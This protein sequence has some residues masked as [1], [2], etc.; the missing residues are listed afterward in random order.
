MTVRIVVPCFDEADRLDV[1]A[2]AELAGHVDQV[3]FVD[4]GSTDVVRHSSPVAPKHRS[5]RWGLRD[6]VP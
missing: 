4:D 2:F 6:S 3:L 1:D 5:R